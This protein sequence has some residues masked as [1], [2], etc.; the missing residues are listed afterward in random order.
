MSEH[1][2]INKMIQKYL[3]CQFGDFVMTVTIH[4]GVLI[5][6]NC[7]S[8]LARVKQFKNLELQRYMQNMQETLQV[9]KSKLG[10]C[11]LCIP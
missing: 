3:I 1:F 4:T 11:R 2:V 6:R 10:I 5:G 9:W 7:T 8:V